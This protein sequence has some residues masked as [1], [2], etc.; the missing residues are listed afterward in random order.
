MIVFSSFAVLF[1]GEST[2]REAEAGI[3]GTKRAITDVASDD[4]SDIDDVP[5]AVLVAEKQKQHK[6][7][8]QR[9]KTHKSSKSVS[10]AAAS[11]S[12]AA[13]LPTQ[14]IADTTA[15]SVRQPGAAL[16]V[17]IEGTTAETTE[18]PIGDTLDCCK[19]AVQYRQCCFCLVASTPQPAH[20]L[21]P[22][23]LPST[24]NSC[25]L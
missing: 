20:P 3:V 2:T 13:A 4:S 24:T 14:Q 10:A 15:P 9:K 5:L 16:C 17:D 8:K 18:E 25:P 6:K 19:C 1:A 7:N 22:S 21:S 23:D 11:S 12:T